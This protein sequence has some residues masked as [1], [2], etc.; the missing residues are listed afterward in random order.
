M[1]SV[2]IGATGGASANNLAQVALIAQAAV[3]YWDIYVDDGLAT[4]AVL[5]DIK[6]IGGGVLATGGTDFFLDHTANGHDFYAPSTIIELQTGV[7]SNGAAAD[8]QIEIDSVTLNGGQFSFG[9]V[10]DGVSTGGGAGFDLWTVLVHEIGHALGFLSFGFVDN[11][12][13]TFDEFL[14]P[15]GDGRY[16]FQTTDPSVTSV[17]LADDSH[18]SDGDVM[19]PAIG[20][21]QS[22]I[23]TY[24]S[25]AIFHDIGL[26]LTQATPGADILKAGL[27]LPGRSIF[28]PDVDGL[29]GDDTIYGLPWEDHLFGNAG[30]DVLNGGLGR[31]SLEGGSGADQL[32]GGDDTDYLDAGDG[33]D[34]LYGDNGDDVFFSGPGADFMDGG[35]GLDTLGYNVQFGVL[36]DLGGV[37][38]GG[39]AD[40]DIITNIEIVFG[41]NFDD[42]LIGDGSANFLGG[43]AGDDIFIGGAGA[44]T[45]DGGGGFDTADYSTSTSGIGISLSGV[46][47]TGGDAAG[48]VLINITRLIGSNFDDR[49]VGAWFHDTLTGGSGDDTLKGEDGN[50]QLF[51]GLGNDVIDGGLGDDFARTSN[52]RD[53]LL[54][55]DGNDTLGAGS[56]NDL[57]NGNAGQDFLLASNGDD[58]LYGGDGDDTMLGGGG[59]DVLT[60]GAGNDRLVG[61]TENDHFNFAPGSGADLIVD[62]AAGAAAG[63]IIRLIGFGAAF[64]DLAD[65]LAASTQVGA[66]VLIALG[67]GDTITL[68]GTMI[69]ALGADDFAFG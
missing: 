62:F 7:D 25:F 56:G 55:G 10:V 4:L 52:G 2:A 60:G 17:L 9:P 64:D 27:Y 59:R 53:T 18:I 32:F 51:A 40:G 68:Q 37:S 33:D 16:N 20:I 29:G 58:R 23:L 42:T 61:G 43:S 49:I 69:G 48:D 66:N 22:F 5:I 65:V 50:D 24:Q 14:T 21:G 12:R 8:I 54:G 67:G 19:L 1:W 41:G 15:L 13:S 3:N 6:P 63:D 47:G 35:P 28:D 31:D 39:D 38:A 36:I 44:D 26:P 11:D 57:L 45:L 30:D 34:S 46:A